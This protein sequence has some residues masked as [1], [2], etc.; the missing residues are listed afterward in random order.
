[1]NVVVQIYMVVCIILLVFDIVFL[2]IKNVRNQRFYPQMPK[3]EQTIRDEIERKRNSGE[4]SGGYLDSLRGKIVKI[5]YL[6]SLQSVLDE[7][8]F[9]KNWFCEVIFSVLD[10][11]KKKSDYEQAYYAYVISTLDYQKLHISPEFASEFMY[12][13]NSK[14]LYTLSNTM[15][16]VYEFGDVNLLLNAIDIIDKRAG[17]YH[18]KLLVDGLLSAK[19]DKEKLA[20][21]LMKNYDKYSVYTKECLLEYF[22]FAG[23][24]A[25]EFCMKVIESGPEDSEIKYAAERYFIKYPTEKSKKMFSDILRSEEKQGWLDEMLAI[26]G[27]GHCNDEEVRSLIKHKITSSNWY[28]RVN[29]V[30]YLK[31]HGMDKSEISGIIELKDR[32]T[33]ESLLYQYRD[34]K[35]MSEYIRESIKK[36]EGDNT[37]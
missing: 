22:R 6:L 31:N 15:N 19:V 3:F 25:S 18:K 10:D 24:I 9:A 21:S 4:F 7:K 12:F 14:S 30:E 34:D 37:K 11:Y 35:E 13:L 26:Q 32:Y 29:A 33:N 20:Q 2:E 27:L 36:I 8:T 28:V 5:K 17:F 1:M 16:A 23:D